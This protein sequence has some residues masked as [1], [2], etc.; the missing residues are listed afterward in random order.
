MKFT[1]NA[2]ELNTAC[3][4]VMRAVSVKMTV[5]TIEGILM[6]CGSDTLSV[7]TGNGILGSAADD[8]NRGAADVKSHRLCR[9]FLDNIAKHLGVNHNGTRL[10]NTG[11]QSGIDTKFKVIAGKAQRIAAAFH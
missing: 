9:Q 2:R 5:P 3:N 7:N 11:L 1:C 10:G 4:N 8:G 6:E